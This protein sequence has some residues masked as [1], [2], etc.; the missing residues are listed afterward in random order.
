ML[1]Y[2]RVAQKIIKAE[3]NKAALTEN[4]KSRGEQ[5]RPHLF[6]WTVHS[7]GCDGTGVSQGRP[8]AVAHEL[9]HLHSRAVLQ[10][11]HLFNRGE[12]RQG[13]GAVREESDGQYI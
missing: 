8:L 2:P 13:E 1:L 4:Y 11:D 5:G 7:D 6:P 12:R 3:G 10:L 9:L